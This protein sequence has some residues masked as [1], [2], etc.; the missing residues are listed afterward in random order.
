M[1]A[2][3]RDLDRLEQWAQVN[4]MMFNKSMCKVLHLSGNPCYLYKLE[5]AR[6][7]HS[8]AKKDLGVLVVGKLNMRQ[9][10]ALTAQKAN[11]ILGCIKR[12]MP[13]KVREVILHFC[14]ALVTPHLEYCIQMWSPQYILYM[15]LL[16]CVQRRATE[17]I[18]GMEYLPL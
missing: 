18:Q 11:C 1:D 7:E 12:S 8:P 10:S 5:D 6:I 4:L 15:D 9:Q 13:S 17:V 14:S 3:Q 2:I 16:D